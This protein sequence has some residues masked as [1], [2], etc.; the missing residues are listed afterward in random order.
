[1]FETIPCYSVTT[2]LAPSPLEFEQ[3]DAIDPVEQFKTATLQKLGALTCA[4]HGKRPTVDFHGATLRD[5]RI[6]MRCCCRRLSELAN[7]AIAR[8]NTGKT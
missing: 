8:P 1:M 6:S 3:P 5:I 2:V 4:A 7:Q